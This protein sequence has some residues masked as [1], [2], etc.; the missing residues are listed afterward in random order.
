MISADASGILSLEERSLSIIDAEWRSDWKWARILP[1]IEPLTGRCVAD[2]GCH[3]VYFMFRM[4]H[5][6]PEC[7]VGFEPVAKHFWN[8]QLIKNLV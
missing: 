8:F 1:H 4:A 7:V 6:Q 3:N 2:I 5:Q